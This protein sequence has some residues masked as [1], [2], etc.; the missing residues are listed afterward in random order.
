MGFGAAGS[1][2][3][4]LGKARLC[5]DHLQQHCLDVS[6]AASLAASLADCKKPLWCMGFGVWAR[7]FGVWVSVYE[8]VA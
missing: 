4:R 6:L 5:L 1:V 8:L 7:P 2:I 3:L